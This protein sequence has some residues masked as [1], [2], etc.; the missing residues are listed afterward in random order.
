MGN[1]S[2]IE[3]AE[4]NLAACV[5]RVARLKAEAE[6]KRRGTKCRGCGKGVPITGQGRPKVWCEPCRTGEP[7]KRWFKQ[8]YGEKMRDYQREYRRAYRKR[9]KEQ[10][11]ELDRAARN[12]P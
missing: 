7:Y 1:D 12:T 8:A 11:A 4:R 6:R 3:A 5:E 9:K 10:L 2:R